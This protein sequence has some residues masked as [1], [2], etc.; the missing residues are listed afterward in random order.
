MLILYLPTWLSTFIGSNRFSLGGVLNFLYI[1]PCHVRTEIIL[2]LFQFRCLLFPFLACF[3]WLGLVVQALY[4]L[5]FCTF[6]CWIRALRVGTLVLAPIL[7]E[8]LSAFHHWVWC[9]FVVFGLY[10]CSGSFLCIPNLLRVFIVNRF[11]ILPKCFLYLEDDPMIFIFS[12]VNVICH[13]YYIAYCWPILVS[14]KWILLNYGIWF[15]SVLLNLV[16]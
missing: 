13:I 5:C 12:S 1:R 7:E 9:R 14:Q 8:K 6:L 16:Y 4:H 11:W 2:L 15:F 10:L 3:L